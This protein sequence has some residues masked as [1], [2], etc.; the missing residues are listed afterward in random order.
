MPFATDME[1]MRAIFAVAVLTF[2]GCDA[3]PTAVA[4]PPIHE[5]RGVVPGATV[6]G[7]VVWQ[8]A[9]PVVESIRSFAKN[10]EGA[11][12][13]TIR[14]SPNAPMIAADGGIAGA[15]VYLRNV[16]PDLA[17]PWDHPPV[18]IEMDTLKPMVRQSDGPLTNIG[19]VRRGD[20]ITIVSRE[21]KYHC[22]RARG[23]DFWSLTLPDADR[24]RT[25]RMNQLGVVELSSGV[26]YFWMQAYVWV[27]EHP[28]YVRTDSAGRWTLPQVPPGEYQLVAW[29]PNWQLQRHERD[30]ET[31]GVARYIYRPPL[32][33]ARP[34]VVRDQGSVSIEDLTINP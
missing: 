7:R 24:P 16:D 26:S 4:P 3:A 25:R 33:V 18:T 11:Y 10:A 6:S 20:A 14:P 22:L 29:L 28:Y 5:S 27:C 32:Q 34:I 2:V 21:Q 31:G 13:P 23:A 9:P 15:V 1:V 17:R 30:P 8:G 19:F 12:V